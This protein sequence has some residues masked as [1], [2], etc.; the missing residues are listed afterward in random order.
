[1]MA[2]R[3]VNNKLWPFKMTELWSWKNSDRGKQEEAKKK[4]RLGGGAKVNKRKKGVI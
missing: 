4:N 1:M 2:K 3:A